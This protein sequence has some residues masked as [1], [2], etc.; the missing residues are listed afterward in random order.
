MTSITAQADAWD[1]EPQSDRKIYLLWLAIFWIGSLAGFASDIPSFL[2][3]RPAASIVI[4]L[5]AVVFTA[6]M[7]I[8]TAQIVLVN[9]DRVD[10]H[11]KL[12]RLAV[13]WIGVMVI[14]GV[15]AGLT[16]AAQLAPSS[17][18][19]GS[20]LAVNLVDLGGLVILTGAALA[21]RSRP[22]LHKR[23]MLLANIS[24]ADP[25]FSRLLYNVRVA[26]GDLNADAHDTFGRFVEYFYGN[27][28]LIVAMA[29]WDLVR[30]GR[31]HPV[32][33]VGA[34]GLLGAE[35]AASFLY[36]DPAW[37]AAMRPVIA[38]WPIHS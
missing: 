8:L 6:W 9:R 32:F 38:L 28:M 4:H 1:L 11:M 15:V 35:Y 18:H 12:G 2:A 34:A 20:L 29:T 14:M 3:Q 33:V 17:K 19:P 16:Y 7:F 37:S 22:A 26:L 25:G 5:H 10:L 23:L 36:G 24:L 31:L 13:G 21:Y 27:V 30:R